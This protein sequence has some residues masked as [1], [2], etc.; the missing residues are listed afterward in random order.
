MNIHCINNNNNI[1]Y[2]YFESVIDIWRNLN[3]H[4]ILLIFI[5]P[6]IFQNAMA[7]DFHIIKRSLLQI[8]CFA[9]P[10][11]ILTFVFLVPFAYYGILLII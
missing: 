10:C 2:S 5:P 4:L 3:P 1:S 8:I 7:L 11:S 6:L 9:I